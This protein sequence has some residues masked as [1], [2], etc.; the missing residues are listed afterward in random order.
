MISSGL[1]YAVLSKAGIGR[2]LSLIINIDPLFFMFA[3]FIYIGALFVASMRWKLLL[4]DKFSLKKLFPLYLLGS[5]FNTFLPGLVGGDAVKIYY[6]YKE[7]G[8]GAQSLASVFMDRYIGYIT[9]MLVG[10]IAFP[11]GLKY[12]RGT[13]IEWLLPLIVLVF[14][15]LSFIILGLRLGKRVKFLNDIYSYFHTYRKKQGVIVKT[16]LLSIVVQAS[17]IYS[18]YIL[19]RGLGQQIPVFIFFLFI[20]I[21][22]TVAA[23]PISIS[24]IG[25]RE[26]AFTLLMGSIGV[27]PDTATA[28][29]FAWFLTFVVG[30]LP[31]IYEYLRRRERA[32]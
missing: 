15:L 23:I 32:P 18:V 1:L 28:I 13:W 10:L 21:I 6:L 8:Q 2:V 14:M 27:S 7:T 9:L 5:F 4:P 12:F 30:G 26:A 24:G 17:I 3:V 11:L 16:I 25:V 22:V 20:P 31:G 19:S 29:S